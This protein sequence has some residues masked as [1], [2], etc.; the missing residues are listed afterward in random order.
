MESRNVGHSA[1]VVQMDR[2]AYSQR[3][4]QIEWHNHFFVH[5]YPTNHTDSVGK[6]LG[7]GLGLPLCIYMKGYGLLHTRTIEP[8]NQ[9]Y[10]IS[11]VLHCIRSRSNL[12]LVLAFSQ[13]QIFIPIRLY[14]V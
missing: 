2:A 5:A 7:M 10:F 14:I 9:L 4:D 12:D 1:H 8:I 6:R 13:T 11:F 3:V